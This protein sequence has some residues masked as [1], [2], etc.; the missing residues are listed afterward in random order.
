MIRLGNKELLPRGITLLDSLLRSVKDSRH[1]EHRHDRQ[2]FRRA[3]SLDGDDEHL[4]ESGIHREIRHLSTELRQFSRVVERSE[5]PELVHR[6]ED[7]F[8]PAKR[9]SRRS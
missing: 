5:Y 6:V 2:H 7:V 1:R 8:L 9:V 4:G 3:L